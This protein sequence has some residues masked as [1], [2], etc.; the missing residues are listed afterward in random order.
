MNIAG[1]NKAELLAALY[2]RARP[3]GM[4]FLHFTPEDMTVAQ[5]ERILS[6]RKFGASFDYLQGRVMKV[7]LDGD[8]MRTDL[9]NRDN[10][11]GA[12]EAIIDEFRSR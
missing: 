9:Y 12:A 7:D 3:Q 11:P 5:A 6:E 4:G 1:I 8:E 2:N 10:G